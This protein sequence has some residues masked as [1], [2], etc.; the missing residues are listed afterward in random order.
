[1]IK[2]G[3][4]VGTIIHIG[5]EE[6]VGKNNL[7][8]KTFVLQEVSDKEYK[9]SIAVDLIKDRVDILKDFKVWDHVEASLNFRASEYNGKFYN[10]VNAWS[11]K[12]IETGVSQEEV[13]EDF[14]DLPF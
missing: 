10:G 14:W 9:G 5:Q 1:M 3:R 6:T 8:K 4:F 11:V 13:D 2:E 7:R 12:K